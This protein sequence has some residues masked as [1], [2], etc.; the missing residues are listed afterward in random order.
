MVFFR[1]GTCRVLNISNYPSNVFDDYEIA[2][3][4]KPRWVRI[5]NIKTNRS[6]I[7]MWTNNITAVLIL[8]DGREKHFKV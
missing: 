3:Y 8:R 2:V 4:E 1:E 7:S 5:N 6:T